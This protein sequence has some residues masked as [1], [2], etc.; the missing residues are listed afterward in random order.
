M[1]RSVNYQSGAEYVKYF[2]VD[3][4]YGV[5][6]PESGEYEGEE[7]NEEES[8]W[9]LE[10]TLENITYAIR[11]E[12]PSFSKTPRPQNSNCYYADRRLWAACDRECWPILDNGSAVVIASEY[13]GLVSLS[14][15]PRE[16]MEDYDGAPKEG[17]QRHY[18]RQ[19][20]ERIDRII[21]DYANRLVCCGRFSNGE[22]VYAS[23]ASR[24][25]QLSAAIEG[26]A[27]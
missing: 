3:P 1:S 19:I 26:E 8:A 15:V 20:E 24:K 10:N 2:A 12:L 5:Y 27:R 7:Y 17:I 18:L 11:Q 21:S 16:G 13:C 4:V 9:E 25:A 6:N 14:F 23:A 22:A